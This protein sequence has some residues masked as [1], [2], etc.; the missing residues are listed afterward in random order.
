MWSGT[1][2]S[3]SPVSC[4][5]QVPLTLVL[6]LGVLFLLTVHQVT[7]S[8]GVLLG[9]RE[10]SEAPRWLTFQPMKQDRAR[11][12]ILSHLPLPDFC[13]SFSLPWPSRGSV[14]SCQKCHTLFAEAVWIPRICRQEHVE[15]SGL[16][17]GERAGAVLLPT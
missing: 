9:E 14:G 13:L 2:A 17:G 3:P 4:S 15:P 1:R 11:K 16:W 12:V 6:S 7:F 5:P 8:S 10:R